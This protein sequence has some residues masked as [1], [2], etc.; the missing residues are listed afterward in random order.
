MYPW[1][2]LLSL[3]LTTLSC[4]Q[5]LQHSYQQLLLLPLLLMV[6]WVCHRL[7]AAAAVLPRQHTA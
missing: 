5:L 1:L 2:P 6:S 7:E 3:L 4:C